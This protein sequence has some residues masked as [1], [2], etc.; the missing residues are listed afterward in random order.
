MWLAMGVIP[1]VEQSQL[2]RAVLLDQRLM[3]DETIPIDLGRSVKF[4]LTTGPVP[5]MPRIVFWFFRFLIAV[6]HASEVTQTISRCTVRIATESY[7]RD[8]RNTPL[9]L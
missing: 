1:S 6:Q 7:A 3:T 9:F 8:C 2:L 5:S 4:D